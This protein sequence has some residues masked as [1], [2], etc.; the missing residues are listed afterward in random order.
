MKCAEK[1]SF[2]NEEKVGK[3]CGPHELHHRGVE[4][5][6]RKHQ[7]YDHLAWGRGG[8]DSVAPIYLSEVFFS[9]IS[10][11]GGRETS[12][13]TSRCARCNR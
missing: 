6:A 3:S 1:V 13:S 2:Q 4:S 8:D 9:L 7:I 5:K 11:E 10:I 12:T